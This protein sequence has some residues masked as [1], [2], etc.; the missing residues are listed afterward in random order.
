M[1]K[2]SRFS[3]LYGFIRVFKF[4]TFPQSF[5]DSQRFK[6]TVIMMNVDLQPHSK[7]KCPLFFVMWDSLVSFPDEHKPPVVA[8]GC[9]SN[10][11]HCHPRSSNC[12]PSSTPT[13]PRTAR[14]RRPPGLQRVS[15]IKTREPAA[16]K[17]E[18]LKANISKGRA[19]RIVYKRKYSSFVKECFTLTKV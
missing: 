5:K 18:T 8:T 13:Q 4:N 14:Q 16:L 19:Y 11:S 6:T 1:I 3:L 15:Y 9:V 10:I 17:L 7:C 2:L 12:C